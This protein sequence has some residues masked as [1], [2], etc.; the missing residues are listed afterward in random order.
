M[1]GFF[2]GW[3][4]SFAGAIR[5]EKRGGRKPK[6]EQ[7]ISKP[8]DS[9]GFLLGGIF[10]LQA[11]FAS[12]AAGEIAQRRLWIPPQNR[13]RRKA[14]FLLV[15]FFTR[16]RGPLRNVRGAQAQAAA[17]YKK[18]PAYAGF[19]LGGNSHPF[20]SATSLGTY[21]LL[22]SFPKEKRPS[23]GRHAGRGNLSF[24]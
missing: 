2:I 18:A 14:G 3:N 8:H 21:C 1:Q 10:H 12:V 22:S 11:R 16:R 19:L 20:A 13:T 9:G 24:S 5:S 15:E 7:K 23:G 17:E 4:L 6:P